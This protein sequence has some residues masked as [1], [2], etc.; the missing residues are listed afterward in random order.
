[1]IEGMSDDRE[2]SGTAGPPTLT[3]LRGHDIGDVVV[4]VTRYFGGTKLG[5][6]GLVRAYSDAARLGLDTLTTVEKMPRRLLSLE[7]PYSYYEPTKRL[8]REH[9]GVIQDETFAGEVTIRAILPAVEVPPFSAALLDL[10]AGRVV[11]VVLRVS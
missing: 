2:P 4:V 6:G 11:P 8:I 10:T 7:I 5:T 1:V 3:V 9:R